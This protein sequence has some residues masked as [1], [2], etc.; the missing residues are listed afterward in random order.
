MS[1]VL[2]RRTGQQLDGC[3]REIL[4]SMEPS[5]PL[6]SHGVY[7]LELHRADN[8]ITLVKLLSGSTASLK[9]R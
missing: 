4:K 5:I 8:R 3:L 6:S 9:V 2:D 1:E 7:R